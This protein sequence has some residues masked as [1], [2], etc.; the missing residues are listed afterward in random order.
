MI[1][2]ETRGAYRLKNTLGNLKVRP[3]HIRI[4][5]LVL[6]NVLDMKTDHITKLY[7]F[8]TPIEVLL[9]INKNRC[10]GI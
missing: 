4:T 7:S 10:K 9:L 5:R 2:K 1:Q 3:G 8:N 6:G